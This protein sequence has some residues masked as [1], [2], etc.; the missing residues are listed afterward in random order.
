VTSL[1][2]P[3]FSVDPILFL[4]PNANIQIRGR[5]MVSNPEQLSNVKVCDRV[6]VTR[7]QALALLVESE[8]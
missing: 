5:I 7:R 8:G 1:C 3:L 6:V 2:F 4:A